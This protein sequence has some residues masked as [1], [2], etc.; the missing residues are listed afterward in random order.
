MSYT[1]LE[2]LIAPVHPWRDVL[3]AELGELGFDS[4]E[5][6]LGGMR[7]YIPSD[8]Y[9]RA[10][11]NGLLTMRDPHV[12]VSMTVREVKNE[13]WNALWESSFEPVRV[14]KE[15]IIRAGFHA[16]EAGFRHELVITPRMAFGTGHHATT[17]MMVEAMLALDL[18]GSRVCDMGCGTGV[19]AILAARMGAARILAV[20]YD[21]QAVENAQDNVRGNHCE[22]IVVEKGDVTSLG[23]DS[24]DAILANIERNTLLRGMAS[25]GAALRAGGTLLL[26]GFLRPDVPAMREGAS[27]QGLEPIDVLYRGEWALLACRKPERP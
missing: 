16:A 3:I 10:A 20:D 5:E 7:A 11:L 26:S 19:L 23:P 4:F 25:L 2:F 27:A 21:M 17:H 9:E 22:G 24:Y 8:R 1:E 15:V 18:E 14:G 6:T 12:R 13:N